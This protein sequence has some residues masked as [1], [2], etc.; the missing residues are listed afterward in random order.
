MK[1]K[2]IIVLIGTSFLYS[3][4]SI[5]P[6]APSVLKDLITPPPSVVSNLNIPV[7][8][9]LNPYFLLAEKAVP[10]QYE[11][12]ENP[13]EGL[14]YYY[15]FIRS[16]FNISGNKDNINLSFEGRYKIKGSYC[17][18]CL[19]ENCL[20]PSPIFSCGFDEPLRRIEIG[21]S[22]KIKLLPNY[23]LSTT[24]SLVKA[25]AVDPC[26]VGFIN[27]DITDKLLKEVKVQLDVLGK[28]VDSQVQ[29]YN[30]KPYVTGFWNKLFEVQKVDEYGYLNLNP[31][32]V[33]VSNINMT[34][35]KLKLSLGLSCRPV[36]SIGYLPSQ[37]TSLPNLS[38]N[39]QPN[40]FSVYTDLIA[41]YT[42]LN[43]L[44]N[45]NLSGKEFELKGKK[46]IINTVEI[47]GIGSSKIAVKL[48]FK[49]SKKG[50]VYLVGTPSFDSVKNTIT[51]PDLT[52]ELKSRNILLKM[53]NW[54]LNDQLTE[55]IKSVAVFDM[56][57]I[58]NQTKTSIQAQLNRKL[59]D[60]I[61]MYGKV[62]AMSLK[63]IMTN[64][65]SLFLRVLSSGEIG[66]KVN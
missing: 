39:L 18:K 28:N 20:L 30:L 17:A 21:Y 1:F 16:P 13:C 32:A 3:C 41:N 59:T 23:H 35:T 43:L 14:R 8:I 56:N 54:L 58:L 48:D 49:G 11:G 53:A 24:T 44:L 62:D 55:K 2:S 33:S 51:I 15:Q 31:S 25:D 36:F 4:A 64:S 52:F 37:P 34:G 27:F 38:N 9:D 50:V 12:S 60:N 10:A 45:K 65:E 57:S 40:G 46:I 22:S 7:E 63:S 42:D 19:K 66:V 61:T 26:K 5:K 6:E 47:T 29:S